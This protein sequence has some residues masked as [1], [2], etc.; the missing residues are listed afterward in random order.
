MNRW[1]CKVGWVYS[2]MAV[3]FAGKFYLIIFYLIFINMDRN[4]AILEGRHEK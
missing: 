2:G 1:L 3:L 4:F